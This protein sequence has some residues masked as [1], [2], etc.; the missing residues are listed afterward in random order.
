MM[1]SLIKF[2]KAFAEELS[3][4]SKKYERQVE[5]ANTPDRVA[6]YA[7]AMLVLAEVAAAVAIASKKTLLA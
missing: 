3:E 1:S 6:A 7:T 2:V 5:S 4:A